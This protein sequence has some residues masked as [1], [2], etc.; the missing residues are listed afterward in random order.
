MTIRLMLGVTLTLL[1][2]LT[3]FVSI[4]T[5]VQAQTAQI[6]GERTVRH[7]AGKIKADGGLITM[8]K[9]APREEY[10]LD[11]TILFRSGFDW[12]PEGRPRGGKFPGLAGGT[13]TGGCKAVDKAGWSARQTWGE[14][15]EASLY[16]YHQNRRNRCGD[17]FYYRMNGQP[18][19]FVTGQQY[20]VTQWVKVNTPN[21]LNGEAEVWIDGKQVL[22]MKNLRLR[23]SV[24]AATAR[25]DQVKYHSYFGGDNLRFAPKRDS[26]TEYGKMYVTTCKPNF[27]KAPGNC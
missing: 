21:A 7:L 23:G 27:A 1:T 4:G 13:G 8:Y 26:Y 15:G 5:Q 24:S 20:R 10:Y 25:V 22:L 18:F 11:Y 3:G 6:L 12:I 14:N 2:S 17:K 9:F 16:L 19:R